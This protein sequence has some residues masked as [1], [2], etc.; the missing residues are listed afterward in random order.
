[1]GACEDNYLYHYTNYIALRG[2]LENKELWL[3]NVRSMNDTSEMLHFMN[4]LKIAVKKECPGKD[5]IIDNLFENQI[6]KLK[7]EQAYSLSLSELYDDAAQWER[8]ANEGK[9]VLI[10][11]NVTQ[12]RKLLD[13]KKLVLQQI[14]YR[15]DVS[16]HQ[17]KAEIV[18]YIMYGKTFDFS[19]IDSAFENAWASSVAFKHPSFKNEMEKR[20]TLM[21]FFSTFYDEKPKYN[22]ESWGIRE[23][24]PLK[25]SNKDDALMP[26]LIE[27]I[28]IGPRAYYPE[29]VF[30]RYL[31]SLGI[32]NILITYSKC[33]LR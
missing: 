32:N 33:P 9:G 13:K 2:I 22:M 24:Y 25:I 26:G 15:D 14:F 20:I 28:M 7:T 6:N 29:G 3:S 18:F 4:C 21:S 11:F 17:V 27:E 19:S 12:L 16:T 31:K 1:M 5:D 10:K 8:Y 30:E 23:Y